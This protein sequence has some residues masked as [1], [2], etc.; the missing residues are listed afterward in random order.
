MICRTVNT[1][2]H[3][4][5][6]IQPAGL[7][8]YSIQFFNHCPAAVVVAVLKNK[9]KYLFLWEAACVDLESA[10]VTG[11]VYFSWHARVVLNEPAV[12]V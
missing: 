7:F 12:A 10:V 2:R 5:G 6:L 3:N 1:L 11:V 9:H 4:W 8:C